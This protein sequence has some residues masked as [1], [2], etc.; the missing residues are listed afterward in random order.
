MNDERHMQRGVVDEESVSFF[1]VLAQAFAMIAAQDD[2]SVAVQAFCFK[3]ADQAS[4]LRIGKSNF[5]I[6]RTIFVFRVIRR[7][8]TIRIVRIVQ[9]HPEKELLL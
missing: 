5:A 1:S 3:K 8:R 4:D 7:G 9:M 6:V 2:Q